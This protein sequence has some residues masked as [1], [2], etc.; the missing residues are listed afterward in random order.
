[1]ETGKLSSQV[2]H[3]KDIQRRCTTGIFETSI[4]LILNDEEN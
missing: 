4:P 3:L 2:K 1:M